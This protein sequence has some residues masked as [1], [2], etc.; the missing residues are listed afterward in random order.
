DDADEIFGSKDIVN[1]P[2]TIDTDAAKTNDDIETVSIDEQENVI[3]E[4]EAQKRTNY[5]IRSKSSSPSS[6]SSSK[7][8]ENSSISTIIST[9][10]EEKRMK[11][12]FELETKRIEEERMR[13]QSEQEHEI[14]ILQMLVALARPQQ[15]YPIASTSIPTSFFTQ[16]QSTQPSACPTAVE[17]SLPESSGD[18]RY[19][20]LSNL[21]FN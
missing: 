11:F 10:I 15:Q 4:P 18:V 12:E 16:I 1:P 6:S 7:R 17:G 9:Q 2:F 20:M 21:T 19:E 14:R 13:R 8:E 5:E 3:I